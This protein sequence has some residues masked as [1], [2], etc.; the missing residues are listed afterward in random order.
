M[1]NQGSPSRGVNPTSRD[2]GRKVVYRGAPDYAAE[3][4]VITG[5][6]R[7]YVFVRYGHDWHGKATSPRDLDWLVVESFVDDVLAGRVTA[8][9]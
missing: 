4:G 7:D 8:D 1:K 9:A 6:S 2:L 3:E 5:F